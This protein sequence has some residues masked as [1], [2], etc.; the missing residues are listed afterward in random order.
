MEQEQFM[1]EMMARTGIKITAN[2]LDIM[3]AGITPMMFIESNAVYGNPKK[4]DITTGITN[5]AIETVF[6]CPNSMKNL[7]C[8]QAALLHE[9]AHAT[10]QASRCNRTIMAVNREPTKVEYSREEIVAESVAA[11]MMRLLEWETEETKR[12]HVRYIE[13]Y[14][15]VLM[16][17]NAY[18]R[19]VMEELAK[20]VQ[21]SI[22]FMMTNWFKDYGQQKPMQQE[23]V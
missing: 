6:M 16:S 20:E 2:I 12:L 3:K 7:A 19:E 9:L 10:G 23:A 1:N 8:F 15:M 5:D 21:T 11:N 13:D 18:S 4:F 22:D 17:E 14:Q